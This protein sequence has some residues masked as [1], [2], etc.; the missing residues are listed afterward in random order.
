MGASFKRAEKERHLA[1]TGYHGLSLHSFSLLNP[2]SIF[3]C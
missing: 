2:D 1:T 3:H